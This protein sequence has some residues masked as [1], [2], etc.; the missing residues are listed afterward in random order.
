MVDFEQ[1]ETVLDRDKDGVPV[2][3]AVRFRN[4]KPR[5]TLKFTRADDDC[6]HMYVHVGEDS[7]PVAMSLVHPPTPCVAYTEVAEDQPGA[8]ELAMELFGFLCQ[9]SAW[10][11]TLKDDTLKAAAKEAVEKATAKARDLERVT[12]MAA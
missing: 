12:A 7:L 4:A 10:S 11:R 5:R 3:Y 2:A 8:R 6:V 9:L 1:L